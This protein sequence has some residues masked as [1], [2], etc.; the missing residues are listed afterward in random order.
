M[1][2]VIFILTVVIIVVVTDYYAEKNIEEYIG[3]KEK[4]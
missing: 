1:Y 3:E 4:K 2:F